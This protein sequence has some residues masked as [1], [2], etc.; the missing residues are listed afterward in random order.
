MPNREI[1]IKGYV[2]ERLVEQ[3]LRHQ[4][5][6]WNNCEIVSQIRPVGC[7]AKGGPYLDFGVVRNGLV[8][9]IYEVK[10]QDYIFV[11]PLNRALKYIWDRRGKRLQ[12]VTQAGKSYKS[13]ICMEAWLCLLVAPNSYGIQAI[14]RRN[15][16]R[17]VLFHEIWNRFKNN[18]DWGLLA[19]TFKEDVRTVL[20]PPILGKNTIK[21]FMKLRGAFSPR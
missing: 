12:Y 6:P 5:P 7:P 18:L 20:T 21:N 14:G 15:L 4:Y 2:G 1:G 17:V 11:G 13:A 16:K 3:W 19:K 8:E 10:M 9:K